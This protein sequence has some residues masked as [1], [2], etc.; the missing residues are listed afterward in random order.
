MEVKR[1]ALLLRKTIG[2]HDFRHVVKKACPKKSNFIAEKPD[3]C[4]LSQVIKVNI[5]SCKSC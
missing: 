1:S 3:R 4:Y 2:E 5:D